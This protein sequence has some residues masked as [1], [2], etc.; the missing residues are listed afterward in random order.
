MK[1]FHS[2]KKNHDAHA[3][4]TFRARITRDPYLDWTVIFF[5]SVL[6][7]LILLLSGISVYMGEDQAL[8]VQITE[9][10]A[11]STSIDTKGL[12]QVLQ[13]FQNREVLRTDLMRGYSGPGDPSL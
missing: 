3:A 9:G 5:F 8:S 2:H 10:R 12:A 13:E 11:N 4:D 6:V 1:L 7:A